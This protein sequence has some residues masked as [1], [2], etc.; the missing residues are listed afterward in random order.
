MRRIFLFII[1]FLMITTSSVYSAFCCKDPSTGQDK[2][3]ATG[4]GECCGGYWYLSCYNVEINVA[5]SGIFRVGQKTQV[6]VY[7]KNTGYYTDSYTLSYSIN[8]PFSSQILVDMTG[9][10]QISNL[11]PGEIK[12]VYPRITILSSLV[13]GTITFT[14][15]S[16]SKPSLQRSATLTILESD[17]YLSLP[18]FST[19]FLIQLTLFVG[20]VYCFL[21]RKQKVIV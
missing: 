9:A 2:C 20:V 4:D 1:L 19:I 21:T 16:Q 15:Q 10:T 12:R 11:T 18:E 7:I 6:I 5:S 14:V 3:Y 17:A 13:T 8:S